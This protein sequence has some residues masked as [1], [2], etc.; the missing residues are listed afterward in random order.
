ML[1]PSLR[2]LILVLVT[3]AACAP[4]D[5]VAPAGPEPTTVGLT[6]ASAASLASIGDTALVRP[7]VLDQHGQ[8]L[9]G[10]KLRWSLS[11]GDVVAQD[12]EGVF[13]AIGNGRVT[14]VAALDVGP[15]GV[16]PAGYWA[17]RLADSVVVE[18]RQRAARLTL[19]PVDTAFGTLGAARQ[20]RVEVTDARGHAMLDG[21]PALTWRS[22]DARVVDVDG[23][24]V[25]RSQG[26]GSARVTVQADALVGA[27]TFT[28]RPRLPHTSCMVFAQRRQTRQACVTL[29]FVV[30]EPAR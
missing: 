26:E 29:D 20:L 24:G 17:D 19:A 6:A 12:A 4:D 30:R 21:P 11:R 8:P 18:V 23:S 10:A 3:L 2:P 1:R 5:V 27:A 14:I 25:V 9:D 28:V 16:R 7:R 13:R 22:A 15:T